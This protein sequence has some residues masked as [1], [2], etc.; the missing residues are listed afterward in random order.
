MEK[1][2]LAAEK[3]IWAGD[4]GHPAYSFPYISIPVIF[5]QATPSG[6]FFYHSHI[7]G[8]RIDGLFG[9]L[10]VKRKLGEPNDNLRGVKGEFIMNIGDWYHKR[11]SLVSL[12]R[13]Y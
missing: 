2:F 10:I 11:A 3:W 9:A 7:G 5:F 4:Y 8:Q 13:P 1:V 12:C 6:T